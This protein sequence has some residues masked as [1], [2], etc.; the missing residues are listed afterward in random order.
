MKWMTGKSHINGN[1]DQNWRLHGDHRV[2]NRLGRW[3]PL[4]I[5]THAIH[6]I[7][8]NRRWE[9][10]EV[11]IANTADRRKWNLGEIRTVQ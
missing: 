5:L 6:S 1:L 8:L 10:D 4:Y 2:R 3:S 7:H 9:V 11:Y